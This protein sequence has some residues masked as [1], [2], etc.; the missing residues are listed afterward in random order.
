MSAP[1][2]FASTDIDETDLVLVQVWCLGGYK[3]VERATMEQWERTNSHNQGFYAYIPRALY[4]E[5][6]AANDAIDQF[7]KRIKPELDPLEARQ[8]RAAT[9]IARHWQEGKGILRTRAAHNVTQRARKA[10]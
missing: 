3:G 10:P 6:R 8:E 4:E 5:M 1:K 2:P 7:W 9:V